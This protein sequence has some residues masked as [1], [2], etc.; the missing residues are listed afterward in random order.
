MYQGKTKH[1]S[2]PTVQRS[3][4]SKFVQSI[5]MGAQQHTIQGNLEERNLQLEQQTT[6]GAKA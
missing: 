6:F 1:K 4:R 5:R 2:K 3:L